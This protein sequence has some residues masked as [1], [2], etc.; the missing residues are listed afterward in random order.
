M[1][2]MNKKFWLI[3]DRTGRT[4]TVAAQFAHLRGFEVQHASASD[5]LPSPAKGATAPLIGIS[6]AIFD[7]MTIRE[8]ENLRAL[9]NGG[10]TLY[11]RGNLAPGNRYRLAPLVDV[12]FSVECATVV[13][14][15]GFTRHAM[16]PAVLRDET[17]AA[18]IAPGFASDLSGPAE[19]IVVAMHEDGRMSPIVFA[20]RIGKA[21]SSAMCN[22]KMK[23]ATSRLSGG[24]QIR[25]RAAGILA[26]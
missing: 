13:P 21:R 10:A 2:H 16:I 18:G 8:R 1:M 7:R 22:R 23:T 4:P 12:A 26:R 11:I 14:A 9:V 19:P 6:F 3:G 15:Y 17:V 24:W 5:G 25:P 20:Y